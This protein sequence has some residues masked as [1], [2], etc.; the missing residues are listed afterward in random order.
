M[1]RKPLLSGSDRP[2]TPA[3]GRCP[4]CGRAF[5]RGVAY[6]SAGALLLSQDGSDSLDTERLRAFLSVGYH[7]KAPDMRDSA[8]LPVVVDLRGG[9]FEIQWCSVACMRASV[10]GPLAE[11]ERTIDTPPAGP[12]VVS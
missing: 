9:Q 2:F 5:D 10:L 7:G 1:P 3:D 6:I 8:D 4:V 12:G 11:L